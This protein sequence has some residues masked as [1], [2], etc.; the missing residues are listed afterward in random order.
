M[1]TARAQVQYPGASVHPQQFGNVCAVTRV[2]TR[3]AAAISN[4]RPVTT[5][6]KYFGIDCTIH[7]RVAL[8]GVAHFQ[9]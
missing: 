3:M 7:L 9:L 2:G 5:T 1:V 8:V 6:A 4:V